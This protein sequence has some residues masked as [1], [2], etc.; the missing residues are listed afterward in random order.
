MILHTLYTTAFRIG[1]IEVR[2]YGLAFVITYLLI[3]LFLRLN[4]QIQTL[5]K[6]GQLE[7]LLLVVSL[8]MIIGARIIFVLASYLDGTGSSFTLYPSTI[9]ALWQG[10]LSFHGGLIGGAV[11]F[12][13]WNRRQRQSANILLD[14]LVLLLPLG[15]VFVRL[16]NFL[17]GDLRGKVTSG[18]W[19]V[20]YPDEIVHRLPYQLYDAASYLIIFLLLMAARRWLRRPGSVSLLFLVLVL[21][22]R[23]VTDFWREPTLV[24]F[25]LTPAQ[26]FSVT[27]LVV[28]VLL[29]GLRFLLRRKSANHQRAG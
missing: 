29:F 18:S 13:I 5:L 6:P 3:Y 20:Q 2:Y 8:G 27:S 4:K 21:L 14:Q 26:W 11:A 25:R 12:L 24:I 10:G 7:D 1:P 9:F 22:S 16:A 15:G 23:L 19:F 17:A 28:L